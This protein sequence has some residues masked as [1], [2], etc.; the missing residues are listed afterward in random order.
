MKRTLDKRL[1][2]F[3]EQVFKPYQELFNRYPGELE[4]QAFIMEL[5][6]QQFAYGM[7]MMFRLELGKLMHGNDGLIFTC[8]NSEY[9]PGTDP[10]ILK[11]KP[12]TQNSVDFRLTLDF[13]LRQPDEIDRAEGIT[14]PY[15]D[16][17]SM[18]KVL[19]LWTYQ[20]GN[21]SEDKWY[22]ELFLTEEEWA[23][24][25]ALNQPLNDRIVECVMDEH[26]RWRFHKFRDDKE[27][28]NHFT[29]V[30]SVITSIRDRVTEQDLIAKAKDI[31]TEWKRREREMKDRARMGVPN[32]ALPNGNLMAG[33]KRAAEDQGG[34]RP[35]PGT[36][37]Q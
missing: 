11:W 34:M 3:R 17:D 37:G 30:E 28:G 8:R 33:Q 10:H 31:R 18:P 19:N 26:R 15:L 36:P 6:S 14:K 20:G 16:Y 21:G 27:N 25:K 13:Q 35:S 4:H 7:E 1:A 24:L 12:E 32:G 5:K 2:Y 9:Q 23:N 29:V 22:G